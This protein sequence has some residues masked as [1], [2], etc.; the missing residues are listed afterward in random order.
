MAGMPV[1]KDPAI[2]IL[3]A[4]VYEIDGGRMGPEDA[5]RLAACIMALFFDRWDSPEVAV[6]EA[7]QEFFPAVEKTLSGLHAMYS[8]M[9]KITKP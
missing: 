9:D 7:K 5:Y 6:E 4:V 2:K 3:S 1:H 8:F